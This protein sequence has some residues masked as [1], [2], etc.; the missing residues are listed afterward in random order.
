MGGAL[1]LCAP[2]L[3]VVLLVATVMWADRKF[4]R[5][6]GGEPKPE[7]APLYG[8]R[9]IAAAWKS[10]LR[11]CSRTPVRPVSVTI[12]PGRAPQ[13]QEQEGREEQRQVETGS[14]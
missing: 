14:C 9:A 11:S 3:D 6:F 10:W 4:A 13:E 1:L 5:R 8:R 12:R 2:L 7:P